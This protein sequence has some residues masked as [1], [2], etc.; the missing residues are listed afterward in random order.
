MSGNKIRVGIVGA[1]FIGA[2][3]ANAWNSIDEAEIVAVC[4]AKKLRAKSGA[5]KFKARDQ[6]W[7]TDVGDMLGDADNPLDVVDVCV[8][9]PFHVNVVG[10]ATEAGKHCVVEKPLGRTVEQCDQ[11]IEFVSGAG[12]KAFP[13]H[14]VRY[15]KP[16][17]LLK[18]AVEAGKVGTLE[19]LHLYRVTGAPSWGRWFFDEAMSGSLFLDLAIHD[20]DIARYITGAEVTG[21]DGE[22]F[23]KADSTHDTWDAATAYL[24][25]D[26]GAKASCYG[27]WIAPHYISGGELREVE[28]ANEMGDSV[29]AKVVGSGG[30]LVFDGLDEITLDDEV[31]ESGLADYARDM[32]TDELRNF[33]GHVLRDEP[34]RVSLEDGRTAVRLALEALDK[35]KA[36]AKP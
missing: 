2:L 15:A 12:V 24:T 30:T 32:Y 11:I 20:I 19:E 31:V 17:V 21:V 13:A 1:G 27:S 6:K 25:F 7:Y 23:R 4:D 36:K 9:T 34:L 8:P 28:K 5:R 18:E 3:H 33:T 29:S 26:N 35:S 22:G 14:V 10:A 16:W